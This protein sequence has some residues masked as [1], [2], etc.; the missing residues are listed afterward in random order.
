MMTTNASR[1]IALCGSM[2]VLDEMLAC[3]KQL[4]EW[5]IATYL[6]TLDEPVDYS[7]LPVDERGQTKARLIRDHID[8]ISKS[9]AVLICNPTF[10]DRINYIGANSFLEMGFAFAFNKHI[11]ILT[12]IPE[13]PNTDEIIG[14]LPI[15][16][17]GDLSRLKD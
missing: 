11:F 4:N 2:R 1:T 6:P 7:A 9:D 13:Q 3:S 5:G 16:L 8:K 12:N 15:C 14:M 17:N 10:D